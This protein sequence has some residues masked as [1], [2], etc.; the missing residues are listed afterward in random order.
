MR[1]ES[2]I[3]RVFGGQGGRD[4]RRMVNIE[5]CEYKLRS[6]SS[7]DFV[8]S[9]K[10]KGWREDLRTTVMFTDQDF[11]AASR[12]TFQDFNEEEKK[13][14]NKKFSCI[15]ISNWQRRRMNYRYGMNG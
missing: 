8:H 2:Q 4:T 13:N 1:V 3:H 5:N 10:R 9:R 11:G 12:Y 15:L 14:K 7:L 6:E